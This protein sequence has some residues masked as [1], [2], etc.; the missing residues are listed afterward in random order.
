MSKKLIGM[1]GAIAVLTLLLAACGLTQEQ[2]EQG[3]QTV[4]SMSPSQL[5]ELSTTV[6]ALPPEVV[7]GAATS[8]AEAGYINLNQDQINAAVSTVAAARATATAVGASAAA[9]ERV[10][11]TEVPDQ[12]PRIIYFFAQIPTQEQAE[13]GMKYWLSY[14]VENAN[15]VEIYGNVMPDPQQ[16][17]FPVYDNQPSD[18]W[19]L[20][21]GNDASWVEQFLQ[22]RPDSDTGSTLQNVTVDSL[23][24]TLSIRDPQF[25]DGDIVNID[26]NGTRMV[27]GY[28]VNGRYNSFPL[29][30]QSG[31]NTITIYARN[32]GATAPLVSEISLS[33]VTGGPATQVT[34]GLNTD[35]SQSFIVTAP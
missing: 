35:E 29:R 3:V 21:A 2:V 10:N 27:D 17:S 22:V 12:A 23:D 28:W 16:G 18:D 31:Q 33:N 9:G 19:T 13:Q 20:W 26:V 7:A 5:A 14:T 15:R 6:Q 11:A 24:V 30:L 25:V 8:A 4:E 1:V 34:R 32:V